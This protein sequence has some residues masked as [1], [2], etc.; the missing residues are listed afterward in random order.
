[1]LVQGLCDRLGLT[2][3][4]RAVFG[5]HGPLKICRGS[6]M[7]DLAVS[8]ADGGEAM[9]AVEMLRSQSAVF[10]EVASDTTV[11]RMIDEFNAERRIGFYASLAA[12]RT[13]VWESGRVDLPR[14]LAVDVDASQV[15]CHTAK[16]G[17]SG[18]YKKEFGFMPII[19]SLDQTREPL[20]ILQRS[21]SDS[22][23]SAADQLQALFMGLAQLP[24]RAFDRSLH[25]IV[26]RIDSAGYAH[27][28]VDTLTSHALDFVIGANLTDA[29]W[30]QIDALDEGA[31]VPAI[32]QDGIEREHAA[33]AELPAPDGWGDGVRLIVRREIAGAGAKLS[34]VDTDGY[35]RQVLITNLP[36]T[37]IAYIAA[38]YCG[39][40]RAEQIIDELKRCGLGK[41]PAKA[42]EHNEAWI[43][44]ALLAA[45]LLRWSQM[46]LLDGH[47]QRVRIGT[48]RNYL[49]HTAAR[50]T[51][52]ARRLRIHF[53]P[54]WPAY[55]TIVRA[56][57]RLTQIPT[58]PLQLA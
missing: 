6:V 24:E 19:C 10:G 4:I 18:T 3:A 11:G 38:L 50:I 57:E 43:C 52:H 34:L 12:A 53:D 33:V 9:T 32:D 54:T 27:E 14:L 20:A 49:L 58:T 28:I 45:T 8:I 41:L 23:K 7:R 2:D 51:S 1:V 17:A 40:G 35:R 39:R 30:A 22:P 25:Q 46:L 42:W 55:Q 37:D 31:W 36:D 29:V 13:R 48:L 26:V 5:P 44:T 21:G 56:F 15:I 16:E 47:W